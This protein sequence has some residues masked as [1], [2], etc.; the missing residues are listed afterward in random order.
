MTYVFSARTKRTLTVRHKTD[1][2]RNTPKKSEKL[3]ACAK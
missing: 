1:K 3:G 2:Q